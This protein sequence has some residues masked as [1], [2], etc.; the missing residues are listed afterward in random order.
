VAPAAG[1][2]SKPGNSFKLKNRPILLACLFICFCLCQPTLAGDDTLYQAAVA[3]YTAKNYEKALAGFNNYLKSCTEKPDKPDAFYYVALIYH[4]TGRLE[5][6]RRAYGF[7]IKNFPGTSGS[8]MAEKGLAQVEIALAPGPAHLPKETWIPFVRHGRSMVVEAK[9][10]SHNVPMIFDTGAERCA[11]SLAQLRQL[12]VPLPSGPPQGLSMGVGK[13]EPTPIWTVKVDLLVGHIERHAFAVMVG[14]LALP[15]PLLGQD[16]FAGME[17]SIDSTNNSISFKKH[18]PVEGGTI[19][20]AAAVT[21]GL[22]VDASGKYVYNVPCTLSG[23]CAVVKV[24]VNGHEL[25]MVF[26]TGAEGCLLTSVQ[27]REAG[28]F[29]DGKALKVSGIGGATMADLSIV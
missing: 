6:A 28:V 14:D 11:F 18:E 29:M 9:V 3:D 10:N 23:E 20:A 21:P 12:G 16:F 17:Y 8:A 19:L 15:A 2:V 7:V 5:L 24:M 22:T 4:Q 27:A 25:P 13:S 26:D 1:Q